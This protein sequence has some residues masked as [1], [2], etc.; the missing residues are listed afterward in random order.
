VVRAQGARSEDN[1]HL[2][3][4][5][6]GALDRAPILFHSSNPAFGPDEDYP[7]GDRT[8]WSDAR[9]VDFFEHRF[10][11]GNEEWTHG[12]PRQRDRTFAAKKDAAFWN[13]L[14]G[15]ARDILGRE[16]RRGKTGH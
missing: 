15:K 1:F 14:G 6:N 5:W 10:G 4:P 13:Q 7:T 11:G 9:I 12:G 16:D 2:P 3:E 8:A